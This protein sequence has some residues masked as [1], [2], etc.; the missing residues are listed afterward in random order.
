MA[1][2]P[3]ASPAAIGPKPVT[4]SSDITASGRPLAVYG[5]LRPKLTRGLARNPETSSENLRIALSSSNFFPDHLKYALA[6]ISVAPND[7]A[8]QRGRKVNRAFGG[9]ADQ[10]HERQGVSDVE[11]KTQDKIATNE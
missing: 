11:T 2:K 4:G 3:L 1:V 9:L 7:P 6:M 8:V 10:L 5:K